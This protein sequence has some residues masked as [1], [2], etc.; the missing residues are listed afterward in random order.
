MSRKLRGTPDVVCQRNALLAY[1]RAR[2]QKHQIPLSIEDWPDDASAQTSDSIVVVEDAN[3][4]KDIEMTGLYVA[5]KARCKVWTAAKS[6]RRPGRV[7]NIAAL[8]STLEELYRSGLPLRTSLSSETVKHFTKK[9]RIMG[10]ESARD[11]LRR[12]VQAASR[13][14]LKPDGSK[15]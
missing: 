11:S 6:A 7:F 5:V 9:P 2:L 12:L 8:E 4:H 13:C 1:E 14:G 15:K 3:S 10:A